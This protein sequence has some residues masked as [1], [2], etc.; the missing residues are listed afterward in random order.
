MDRA[1]RRSPTGRATAEE[2]EDALLVEMRRTNR[3][4]AGMAVKGMDQRQAIAFLMG[5]GFRAAEIA[6]AIGI[7]ANAVSIALH[8]MRKADRASGRAVEEGDPGDGAE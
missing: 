5:A 2:R 1:R 6:S 4:L 3:L 7:T 8:R